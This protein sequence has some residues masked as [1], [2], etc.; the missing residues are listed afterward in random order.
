[1]ARFLAIFIATV[2]LLATAETLIGRADHVRD[3][4]TI[5]VSGMPIRLEGLAAPELRDKWGRA[6]RDAIQRIVAGQR[7]HCELTGERSHDRRIGVCRLDDGSD[8]AALL[9]QQGLGRDCRRYSAGRY[10][11][12][13]IERS[14][15]LPLPDYCRRSHSR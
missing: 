8:I 1:M 11:D 15:T 4:D 6:S 10:A 14:R 12:D 13:E 7:L 2:P 9:V 3:G 5:V